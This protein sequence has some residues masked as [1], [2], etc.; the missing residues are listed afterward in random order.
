[1]LNY[2][3]W[4]EETSEYEY[5]SFE[6]DKIYVIND[7]TR[8]KKYKFL[9]EESQYFLKE[10][11]NIG[12]NIEYLICQEYKEQ[13]ILVKGSK[14]YKIF[15]LSFHFLNE[16]DQKIKFECEIGY[17]EDDKIY[18]DMYNDRRELL[19]YMENN[20]SKIKYILNEFINYVYSKKELRLLVLTG[21]IKK[22]F[23]YMFNQILNYNENKG[24]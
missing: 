15:N 6:N 20:A 18:F 23:S 19:I 16:K 9:E 11:K 21:N 1:M 13:N 14:E 4:K 24:E 8:I 5:G 2:H 10:A 12:I 3:K 17:G 22:N 7:G